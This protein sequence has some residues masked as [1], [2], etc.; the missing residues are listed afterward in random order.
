MKTGL[1]SCTCACVT[2]A[3]PG[4]GAKHT[5]DLLTE[6]LLQRDATEAKFAKLKADRGEHCMRMEEERDAAIRQVE[7]QRHPCLCGKDT[8]SIKWARCYS[9]RQEESEALD[10]AIR[11]MDEARTLYMDEAHDLAITMRERDEAKQETFDMEETAGRLEARADR[12]E[13]LLRECQQYMGG[14]GLGRRGQELLDKIR[15]ALG[16]RQ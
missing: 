16:D 11:E 2:C 3:W 8:A 4:C 15:G 1:P 10:A 7:E 14:L 13:A 12:A 6:A 9:C 5:L